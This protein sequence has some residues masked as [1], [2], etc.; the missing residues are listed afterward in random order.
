MDNNLEQYFLTKEIEYLHTWVSEN[1][2]M[3]HDIVNN[4]VT[5]HDFHIQEHDD[6]FSE[7]VIIF[8]DTIDKYDPNL[9]KLSTFM[10]KAI[11]NGLLTRIRNH[12][13]RDFQ[14]RVVTVDLDEIVESANGKTTVVEEL[15]ADPKQ[16]DVMTTIL[17]Q[18]L[19]DFVNTHLSPRKQEI[20][21]LY[22]EGMN[23]PAVAE[24]L[25]VTKQYVSKVIKDLVAQVRKEWRVDEQY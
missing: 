20:Y 11:E 17:V 22:C 19:N 5:Y 12:K 16:V 8:Y 21:R 3:F 6:L 13:A 18:D 23:I 14:R 4:L 1:Y 7:A 2:T 25:G 24:K 10:Y 9:G 15:I